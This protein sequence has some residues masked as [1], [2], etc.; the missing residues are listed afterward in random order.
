M[1]LITFYYYYHQLNNQQFKYI[2]NLNKLLT[3]LLP[4]FN[5]HDVMLEHNTVFKEK[6]KFIHPVQSHG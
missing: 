2:Y 4:G 5:D 3:V 6:L 1:T